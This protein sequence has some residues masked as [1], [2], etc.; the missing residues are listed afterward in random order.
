MRCHRQDN[1]QYMQHHLSLKHQL[2]LSNQLHLLRQL[3]QLILLHLSVQLR[4]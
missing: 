1:Q 3:V 2:H 4:Q